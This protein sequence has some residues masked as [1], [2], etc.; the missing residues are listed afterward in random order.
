VT[1]QEMFDV[2]TVHMIRQ[3]RRAVS[4]DV[5][6]TC[7]YRTED[8]LKCAVGILIPDSEYEPWM[9]TAGSILEVLKTAQRENRMTPV[10]SGLQEHSQLLI[11]LQEAHDHA[12][13]WEDSMSGLALILREIAV[14]FDLNTD[15]MDAAVAAEMD[16]AVAA[17]K[18]DMDA[19]LAAEKADMDAALAAAKA[20]MDA[21][22][23]AAK[24]DMDAAVAAAKADMDAAVAAEKAAV[25]AAKAAVAAAKADMD[26]AQLR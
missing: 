8:G 5:G 21:A 2:S 1:S 22:A 16:A 11:R 9:D 4:E 12:A 23:A 25:A 15:A 24:A 18:A 14:L 17:E 13:L 6:G 26:G 19:A 10:L 20:D 7:L 3:G